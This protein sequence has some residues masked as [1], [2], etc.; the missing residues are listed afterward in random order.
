MIDLKTKGLPNA[1][2]VNGTLFFLDVDFRVWLS[3]P[4][5]MEKLKDG[6]PAG[7]KGLFKC[8]PPVPTKAVLEALSAFYSPEREIPRSIGSD[9]ALLDTDIDAD[10]IYAAFLQVYGIDLL[11]EDMHWHKFS[12]LLGSLPQGTMMTD[13]ISYRGYK[14]SS[15]DP[16]YKEH[17]KLKSIWALPQLVSEEE[18]EAMEEFNRLFG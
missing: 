4:A 12:A 8:V 5:R 2:E 11:E 15:K 13:I 6:D 10:Y 1:I 3:F 9:E 16:A 18:K 14:G 17:M 7:Y